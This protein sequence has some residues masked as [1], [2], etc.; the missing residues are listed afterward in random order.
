MVSQGKKY[1]FNLGNCEQLGKKLADYWEPSTKMLT[2]SQK[3]LDSLLQFEKDNI[4]A[5]TIE[6][7]EPYIAMEAFTPEQ[8][9]CA[10]CIMNLHSVGNILPVALLKGISLCRLQGYPRHAHRFACG[11][12]P[13]MHTIKF[14]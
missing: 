14:V 7:I 4:T 13:C 6:K 5:S 8:V 2:D 10:T 3:F 11:F 9:L 12:E 1:H